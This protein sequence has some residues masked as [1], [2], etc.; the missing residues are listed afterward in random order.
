MS[1]R[2]PPR[3]NKIELRV[4]SM[5]TI[6]GDVDKNGKLKVHWEGNKNKP[7]EPTAE[8]TIQG[9][10]VAV[11]GQSLPAFPRTD[12]TGRVLLDLKGLPDGFYT[13]RLRPSPGQETNVPAG[14]SLDP[15]G[16]VNRMYRFLDIQF[17]WKNKGLSGRPQP[18]IADTSPK[19][20]NGA[21]VHWDQNELTLDWKP[22]WVRAKNIQTRGWKVPP[23]KKGEEREPFEPKCI[24]LH[25]TFKPNIGSSLNKFLSGDENAHYIIDR[26]GFVVKLVH[27]R[28]EASHA[29][30]GA[31]WDG[32]KPLNAYSVGIEIVNE[33]GPV[34]E[35]QMKSLIALLKALREKYKIPKSYVVG[36][37]EVRGLEKHGTIVSNERIDCPGP[38]FDWQRLE[39][40]GLANGL[41]TPKGVPMESLLDV[42]YFKIP[43]AVP[44][45]IDDNDEQRKYGG[46]V[47]GPECRTTIEQLQMRL[48]DLGYESPVFETNAP[49]S[50]NIS[51]RWGQYDQAMGR[52]V[53]RFKMRYL[54]RRDD[55]L[56]KPDMD[57][58]ELDKVTAYTIRRALLGRGMP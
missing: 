9:A 3:T 47:R 38:E 7:G 4:W 12:Q 34:A 23:L 27:E 13:L 45:R 1:T 14:V 18:T 16:T 25:R 58:L 11:L 39:R 8:N 52:V 37:C 2:L 6:A 44:L 19:P 32:L 33:S 35:A 28:D 17:Y 46:Q 29:G 43:P 42:P 57:S 26:D 50:L 56:Q 21:V 15:P 40:E 31:Q 48:R 20:I 10:S 22:D 30:T 5:F 53:Q 49:P 41:Y 55:E 36:H 51:P 54:A 24:V